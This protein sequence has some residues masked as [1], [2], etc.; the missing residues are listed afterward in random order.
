[1]AYYI[2]GT[3]S[4]SLSRVSSIFV[5]LPCA[6]CVQFIIVAVCASPSA[7]AGEIEN[8]KPHALSVFYIPQVRCNSSVADIRILLDLN[9]YIFSCICTRVLFF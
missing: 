4:L 7:G 5:L 2:F 6:F 3:L 9:F 8:F 1:M